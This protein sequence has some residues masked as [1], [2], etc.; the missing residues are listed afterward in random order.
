[1]EQVHELTSSFFNYMAKSHLF[2]KLGATHK[3]WHTDIRTRANTYAPPPV[4]IFGLRFAFFTPISGE[5]RTVS[6]YVR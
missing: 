4:I 3:L 1:M 6:K 5:K 2:M